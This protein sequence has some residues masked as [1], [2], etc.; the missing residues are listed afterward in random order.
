MTQRYRG[1]F[2]IRLTNLHCTTH[3]DTANNKGGMPSQ[4]IFLVSL[5]T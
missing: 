4:F 3:R 2:A 1:L 5:L